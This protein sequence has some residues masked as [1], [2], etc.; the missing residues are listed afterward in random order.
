MFVSEA[1]GGG[2]KSSTGKKARVQGDAFKR[3]QD[4]NWV[5]GLKQGFDDNTYEVR[6][7]RLSVEGSCLCVFAPEGKGWVAAVCVCGLLHDLPRV[8][9]KGKIAAHGRWTKVVSLYA[10]VGGGAITLLEKPTPMLSASERGSWCR[11]VHGGFFYL[12]LLRVLVCWVRFACHKSPGQYRHGAALG[13]TQ[14]GSSHTPCAA[15]AIHTQ[16]NS[17]T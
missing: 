1:N 7:W 10:F 3:V 13:R 6:G 16:N 4:E 15:S 14:S 9:A 11:T 8:A 2:G 17:V 5:G 12:R